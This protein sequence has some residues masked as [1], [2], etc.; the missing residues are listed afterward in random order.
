MIFGSV[1]NVNSGTASHAPF[2]VLFVLKMWE[3]NIPFVKAVT[4]QT[5]TSSKK[6]RHG[7]AGTVV[8]SC[9]AEWD[10]RNDC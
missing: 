3:V 4:K 5:N 10:Y 2:G 1:L 7:C 9:N 8:P 6:R